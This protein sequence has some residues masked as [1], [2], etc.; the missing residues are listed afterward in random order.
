MTEGAAASR[1]S[2]DA[3]A[4]TTESHE[5]KTPPAGVAPLGVAVV[6][7]PY[8][9]RRENRRHVQVLLDGLEAAGLSPRVAWEPTERHALLSDPALHE[10]C[11]CVVSAGGDGSLADA[12]N[13]IAKGANLDRVTVAMLPLGTENLFARQFGYTAGPAALAAAITE[14]RSRLIDL[15]HVQPLDDTR[16][17]EGERIGESATDEHG[18]RLFT[19]MASSGFDSEVVRRVALWRSSG[20]AAGLRRVNRF[21]Y[22]PRVAA[23]MWRYRYPRVTL[24]TDAGEKVTGAHAFVFNLPQYGMGLGIAPDACEDD[25]LLDWIVFQKPGFW[26]L[27]MYGLSVYRRRHLHRRD[28]SHGR[29]RRI[30]LTAEAPVPAQAD[31]DPAGMTPT[32]IEARPNA[33]RVLVMG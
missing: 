10:W 24:E 30:R 27:G 18:S 16:A 22:G 12:V 8:S 3:P 20:A 1:S 33:M 29:A 28:V 26:P 17:R 13:D 6:G 19:L 15:G 4:M 7:N 32:E 23:A 14:G 21:S 11:R 2:S 5:L 31:G 25:G 9:G